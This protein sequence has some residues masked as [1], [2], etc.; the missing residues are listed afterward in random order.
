MKIKRFNEQF[1]PFA[2]RTFKFTIKIQFEGFDE[3]NLSAKIL[4]ADEEEIPKSIE[5]RIK[6]FSNMR[7]Y[8]IIN[9]E[10]MHGNEKIMPMF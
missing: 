8:E 5:Q 6:V 9:L 3:T 10:E 2:M 1:D 7:S 4:V